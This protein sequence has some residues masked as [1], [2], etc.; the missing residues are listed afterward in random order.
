MSIVFTALNFFEWVSHNSRQAS[1]LVV[2]ILFTQ[3][4]FKKWLSPQWRSALWLLLIARLLWPVS[5]QSSVSIYDVV[6]TPLSRPSSYQT[7]PAASPYISVTVIF[8]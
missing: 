4:L 7:V 1:L 8:L 2:L 5:F 3:F 6:P